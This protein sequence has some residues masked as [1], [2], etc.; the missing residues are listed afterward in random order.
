MKY[1]IISSVLLFTACSSTGVVPMDKGTYMIGKRSA[2]I[3]FGPPSGVK[4]D[5]YKEANSFCA[6][7][8]KTVKTLNLKITNSGLAKPGHV[9]LEF[10]CE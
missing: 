10:K 9:L 6:K 1:I 7:K 5:V 3:G 4:T 8:Q 2:Q